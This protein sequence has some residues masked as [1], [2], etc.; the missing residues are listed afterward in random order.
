MKKEILAK[1]KH[2]KKAY[3]MRKQEQADW[4]EYRDIA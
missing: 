4:K 1:F 2:K 3:K